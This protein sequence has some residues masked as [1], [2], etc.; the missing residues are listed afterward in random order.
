MRSPPKKINAQIQKGK[1][2]IYLV[3]RKKINTFCK[4]K[5]DQSLSIPLLI[6]V[7]PENLN[8]SSCSVLLGQAVGGTWHGGSIPGI[9]LSRCHHM[10]P[11]LSVLCVCTHSAAMLER[12]IPLDLEMGTWWKW[13]IWVYQG[14]LGWL[15]HDWS[16]APP[17]LHLFYWKLWLTF[18]LCSLLGLLFLSVFLFPVFS[19]LHLWVKI[20]GDQGVVFWRPMFLGEQRVLNDAICVQSFAK[21]WFRIIFE[22]ELSL[23]VWNHTDAWASSFQNCVHN[24][25]FC[26]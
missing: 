5:W 19:L 23:A 20:T 1:R 15:G 17:K 2:N 18:G 7:R 13:G 11:P 16:H 22:W 3:L 14:M 10:P 25:S 6:L 9:R 26:V 8:H 24:S 21:L 12:F 4:T